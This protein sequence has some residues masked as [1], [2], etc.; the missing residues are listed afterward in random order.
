[1]SFEKES[2]V[3]LEPQQTL[4]SAVVLMH[5]LGAD[6][7]DFVPIAPMLDLPNTRFVF[8]NAQVMPVTINGG[9]PMRAWF[10][11]TAVE[12]GGRRSL[13]ESMGQ[14]Q[15]A[16]Q[17]VHEL[18]NEQVAAGV[19][20]EKVIFAGFSQGGVIALLAGLTWDKPSAGILALSTYFTP[21]LLVDPWP[22]QPK[23]YMTHGQYDD[24]I[25]LTRAEDGYKTLKDSGVDIQFHTYPMGHEVTPTEI[26]EF[27][28]WL[29][30]RMVETL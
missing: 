30:S 24:V 5:G 20:A 25:P 28:E 27:R 10:D 26:A 8:P 16:V 11:I 2:P 17:Y 7:N 4:G 13:G 22:Q 18:A 15:E 14:I 3:V 12:I 21:E 19:P 29:H 9:M 6:G 1:M 23:V